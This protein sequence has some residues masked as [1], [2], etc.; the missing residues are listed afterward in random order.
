MNFHIIC[1]NTEAKTMMT[2][3][4]TKSELTKKGVGPEHYPG[5]H[6]S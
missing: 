2:N 4:W 3:H 5:A 1:I 6:L